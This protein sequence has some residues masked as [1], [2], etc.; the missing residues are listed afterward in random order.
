MS[1]AVTA[2]RE[3]RQ[4]RLE[5]AKERAE[6]VIGRRAANRIAAFENGDLYVEA[7]IVARTLSWFT[8]FVVFAAGVVA[9]FVLLAGLSAGADL[10]DTTITLLAGALL[11]AVPVLYGLCYGNGR[12]LGAVLTGTRLV[13]V[14]DGGRIGKK[15]CWAMLLRTVLMPL[16]LIVVIVGSFGGS[17]ISPDGSVVRTSIDRAA[18]RRLRDLDLS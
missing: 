15:A 9:G 4:T 13:R 18:T 3:G 7:G 10:S 11:V 5:I 1:E 6:P 12:A 16:L 8:D 2:P 17:L 14:R